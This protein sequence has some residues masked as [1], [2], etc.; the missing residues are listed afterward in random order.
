MSQRLYSTKVKVRVGGIG[1]GKLTVSGNG[2]KKTTRTI[3]SSTVATVT[4]KLNASGKRSYR[5]RKALKLRAEFVPSAKGTKP[6]VRTVT[7]KR[8]AAKKAKKVASKSSSKK[9]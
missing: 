5:G 3:K 7:V 8:A 4:V 9:Q 2:V 1:G 6:Q